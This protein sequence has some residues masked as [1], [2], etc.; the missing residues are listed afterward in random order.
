MKWW[1]ILAGLGIVGVGVVYGGELQKKIEEAKGKVPFDLSSFLAG[2]EQYRGLGSQMIGKAQEIVSGGQELVTT[3]VEKVGGAV[4]IPVSAP[5][6]APVQYGGGV[7][8]G[9]I[10]TESKTAKAE[11]IMQKCTE[12][13]SATDVGKVYIQSGGQIVW[14]PFQKKWI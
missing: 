8:L 9:G 2:L 10:P 3:V 14:N 13:P 1:L 6:S 5:V 4:S 7:S 11:S 12:T